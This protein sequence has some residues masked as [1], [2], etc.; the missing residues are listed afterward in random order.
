M[1]Q[2][3]EQEVHAFTIKFTDADQKFEK[4]VDDSF[5]AKKVADQLGFHYHELKIEPK[6]EELLPKMIWHLDEPLADP[7]AINTYLISQAARDLGIIVLLNG[8]GGDEIFGGYRKQLACLKAESYQ[9]MVPGFVRAPLEKAFEKVP[10]ATGSQGLKMLR[11]SKRFLSF[12]SLPQVE[13][14]LV[15]DLAFSPQQYRSFFR[16]GV[17]YYDTHYFTSQN[18][19]LGRTYVLYLTRMCLNDTKVFLPELNLTYS[20]KATM[21]AGIESRPPLT[22]HR[23]IEVMFV[24]PPN[25]RIRTNVQKYLLKKVSEK[26]SAHKIV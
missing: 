24:L 8:M 25:F 20:D 13:R 17:G 2:N 26:Y 22:D 14:F 15:S 3:T 23:L 19:R 4:M 5:Y 18:E 10:V 7:A 1:R 6:I 21:A 12:A 9:K 16:N 11:W